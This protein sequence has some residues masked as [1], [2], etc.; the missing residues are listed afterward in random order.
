MDDVSV[1]SISIT[2]GRGSGQI[3]DFFWQVRKTFYQS[4]A[5]ADDLEALNGSCPKTN[6]SL[7]PTR[8]SGAD[9]IDSSLNFSESRVVGAGLART[10]DRTPKIGHPKGCPYEKSR[11]ESHFLAPVRS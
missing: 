1:P 11:S 10:K 2:V 8:F 7:S 6:Y 3:E 5:E 4:D 9:R